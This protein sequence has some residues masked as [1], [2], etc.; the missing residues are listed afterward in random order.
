MRVGNGEGSPAGA[1]FLDE[2][3]VGDEESPE[4][5]SE[6]SGRGSHWGSQSEG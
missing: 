6:V 4:R 5:V 3:G 1:F 2:G